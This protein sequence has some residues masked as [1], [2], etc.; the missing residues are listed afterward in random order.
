MNLKLLMGRRK[1]QDVKYSEKDYTDSKKGVAYKVFRVKNGKL[2]PP[3]VENPDGNDTP[4]GV[5][6]EAE[7][8]EFVELDGVKRVLQKGANKEKLMER[9]ANLNNLEGEERKK[10]F[11][12]IK[13]RTLAYRPGWHLGDEPRASQFDRNFSWEVVD[14]PIDKSVIEKSYKTYS[15]FLN[16]GAALDN[17]GKIFYVQD[18]DA[19]IQVVNDDGVYFPFDFV[20][21]ECEYIADID[22]QEE[23]MSYGYS[24]NKKGKKVFKHALAGLPKVPEGGSY[25]YR[26]NPKPDTVAWVITGAIKVNRL[27]DDFEVNEMLGGNA[28]ERQGG[29]LTL[30]ELG[31]K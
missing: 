15:A 9:I 8:G 20:W 24:V 30:K 13:G 4:M 3:M 25:K 14:E 2:Y 10:E 27:I 18:I 1:V 22:Y 31:L 12:R 7:S 17:V 23:A 29:N 28:P 6:L 26:T 19:Y 11:K 16:E 21:A 5:W